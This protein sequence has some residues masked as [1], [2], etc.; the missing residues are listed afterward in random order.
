MRNVTSSFRLLSLRPS[1]LVLALL[2]ALAAFGPTS[3]RAQ[4]PA[5]ERVEVTGVVADIESNQPIS[6]AIVELPGA[7]RRA[8]TNAQGRFVLLDVPAGEQL[9]RIRML[10]YATWEERRAVAH[11]DVLR[12]GLLPRPL[13]LERIS[14]AV[15][16]LE[17]RRRLAAVTVVAVDRE[18]LARSTWG[19][20]V[21]VVRTRIPYITTVCPEEDGGPRQA[22]PWEF[23]I[24]Y[25]GGVMRPVVFLDE[26]RVP[27]EVVFSYHPADLYT[28]EIYAGALG[29]FKAPQIRIYT[30]EFMKR[31]RPLRPLTR[32]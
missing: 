7:G 19:S 23:C 27:M 22:V 1:S 16:R 9:W 29:R 24:K 8:V 26:R 11:L 25:R 31:G 21:E 4:D 10:G 12:I 20:A 30:T 17:E 3:L 18:E 14:V 13:E 15:D 2:F 5:P 32:Y 6:G 28:V